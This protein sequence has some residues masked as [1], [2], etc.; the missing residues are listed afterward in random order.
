MDWTFTKMQGCGNDYI[1]FDCWEQEFPFPEQYSIPLSDRH[2]GVG[3][4]GI[5]LICRSAVADAKMRMFNLDGSE[6]KMCGNAIRCVG[7]YLSDRGRV[8][9]DELTVETLSGIKHL[10]LYKGEDGTVEQVRV[11]M[12]QPELIPEKI[13]AKFPG[14]RAIGVKLSVGL[15]NY[16]VSLVSMGNPHCVTFVQGVDTVSYTHLYNRT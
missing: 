6:G 4:D 15:T 9:R 5:V 2:F 11:N 10:R 14:K 7:K 1:Y 13:P 12:G 3:G 8:C 16:T